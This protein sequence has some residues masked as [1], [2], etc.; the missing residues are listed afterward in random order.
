M[1]ILSGVHAVTASLQDLLRPTNACSGLQMQQPL[2]DRAN[3]E[4]FWRPM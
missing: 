1:I 4:P 2:S 3:S